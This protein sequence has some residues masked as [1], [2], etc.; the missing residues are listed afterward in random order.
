MKKT[1]LVSFLTMAILVCAQSYTFAL[2]NKTVT[3][4][5]TEIFS[6]K[7]MKEM[8]KAERKAARKE[9]K[10]ARKVKFLKWL[11][12][13]GSGDR[14]VIAA[15]ICFFLGG[16]AIHRVYLGG[17]GLLILLYLITIGGIFG[18]LP[19]IDFIR[20]LLGH[21]DHYENNDDFLAAFK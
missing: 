3:P 16:L 5:K 18:L 19:L 8:K 11:A 15:V 20:L 12:E 7:E 2:P 10:Q 6:K 9:R 13:A 14:G 1:L 21:V 4:E 17:S